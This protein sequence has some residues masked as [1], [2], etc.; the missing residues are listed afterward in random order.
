MATL[1]TSA[2][3]GK[4]VT[5]TEAAATPE[6]PTLPDQGT[7]T[8]LPP[9]EQL[10][11]ALSPEQLDA[12][13]IEVGAEANPGVGFQ[14]PLNNEN[15][16]IYYRMLAAGISGDQSMADGIQSAIDAEAG[17]QA[18]DLH[19]EAAATMAIAAT[20]D[21]MCGPGTSNNFSKGLTSAANGEDASPSNVQV[22]LIKVGNTSKVVPFI[23]FDGRV[24][25][26]AMREVLALP[27]PEVA[28]TRL[29]PQRYVRLGGT[30]GTTIPAPIKFGNRTSRRDGLWDANSI[31]FNVACSANEDDLPDAWF[32]LP[33]EPFVQLEALPQ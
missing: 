26:N 10:V 29:Q 5:A 28:E 32:V 11:N 19:D 22:D 25:P 8:P 16:A 24:N 4:I 33:A 20:L 1:L 30:N 18:P 3:G 17:L 2:C 23:G 14:V 9:T 15:A 7:A 27:T 31:G 12:A 13:F 6:T 21:E